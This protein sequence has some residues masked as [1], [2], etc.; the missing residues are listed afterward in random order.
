MQRTFLGDKDTID[1]RLSEQ[2]VNKMEALWLHVVSSESIGL[3][4]LLTAVPK[5]VGFSVLSLILVNRIKN[6]NHRHQSALL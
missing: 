1:V 2:E 4:H 5:L 6:N 3:I